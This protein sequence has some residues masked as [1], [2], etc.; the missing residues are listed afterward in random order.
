MNKFAYIILLIITLVPAHR[1]TAQDDPEAIDSLS[2]EKAMIDSL[3]ELKQS[4]VEQLYLIDEQLNLTS[5]LIQRLERKMRTMEGDLRDLNISIDSS[6]V[7]LEQMRTRLGK[8]LKGFYINYQPAPA[9]IFSAGDIQKAARQLHYFKTTVDFMKSQLD[10]ISHLKT[11]L[12]DNQE[13]LI[14]MRRQ[15]EKLMERK[16]V[17]ESVLEMRR[18]DKSR[19]LSRIDQD[20]ELKSQ[21][22]R[23]TQK[24]QEQLADLTEKLQ[25]I[26]HVVDFESLKGRLAWPVEGKIVRHFGREYDRTTNTETFSP[27]IQIKV[28]S[29]T[30]VAASAAGTVA[31]AGYLRGYGNMVILDHG[32]GWYTLYGHLS[33]ITRSIGENI[34]R[35]EII[36][37]SGE[38]GS[39]LGPV[40]FFGVRKGSQSYDPI[41]WLI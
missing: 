5:R 9:A 38:S 31:H 37:Y 19:L 39:N 41:E 23:E 6:K 28:S 14:S 8:N 18:K 34:D 3:L 26:S 4:E 7:R 32:R 11:E 16:N 22:L 1:L 10:S 15:T 40:L 25:S 2:M 20:V 21:Y 35:G 33:R 30:E 13:R 27:G 17:E 24:D 12:E 36:G 29:G